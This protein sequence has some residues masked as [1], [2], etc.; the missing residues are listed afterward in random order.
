MNSSQ[1]EQTEYL[2]FEDNNFQSETTEYSYLSPKEPRL[3]FDPYLKDLVKTY[4]RETDQSQ[5]FKEYTKK[6]KK[7][8]AIRVKKLKAI[9]ELSKHT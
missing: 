7:L 8:S 3:P 2:S 4:N 5:E 6:L 1:K 9:E